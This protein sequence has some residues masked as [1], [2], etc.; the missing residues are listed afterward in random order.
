MVVMKIL[1]LIIEYMFTGFTGNGMI[2]SFEYNLDLKL[3]QCVPK[4]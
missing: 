1:T 4:A 3:Y 2:V